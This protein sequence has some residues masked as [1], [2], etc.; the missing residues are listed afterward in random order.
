MHDRF[1]LKIRHSWAPWENIPNLHFPFITS[2]TP[3][4][5]MQA[6]FLAQESNIQ[7][8]IPGACRGLVDCWLTV[9]KTRESE[10]PS[11]IHLVFTLFRLCKRRHP[12]K[13]RIR[14]PAGQKGDFSVELFIIVSFSSRRCMTG[15]GWWW[16]KIH[17]LENILH[18]EFKVHF[19]AF[20]YTFPTFA[21]RFSLWL[22]WK[23]MSHVT[24]VR[25]K[26]YDVTKQG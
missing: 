18:Y 8:L 12:R 21:V 25:C 24:R 20:I 16:W 1:P 26:F 22:E 7:Q 15:G 10:N 3:K 17:K 4:W 13:N 5:F 23:S 19:T 6:P 9:L 14:K 2:A 11:K